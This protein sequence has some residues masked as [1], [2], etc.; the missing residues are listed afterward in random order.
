M[1]VNGHSTIEHLFQKMTAPKGI[2]VVDSPTSLPAVRHDC[3]GLPARS[4]ADVHTVVPCS[5][6]C[7]QGADA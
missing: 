3:L 1:H 2:F 6:L 7:D 4:P 5:K